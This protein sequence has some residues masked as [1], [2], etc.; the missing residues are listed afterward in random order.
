MPEI[1]LNSNRI[2]PIIPK[3]VQFDA[4]N[5]ILIVSFDQNKVILYILFRRSFSELFF[6]F[7]V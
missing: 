7:F 3:A 6:A 2:F 5:S 1:Q 4:C